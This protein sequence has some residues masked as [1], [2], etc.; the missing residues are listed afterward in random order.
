MKPKR[1]TTIGNV[2]IL[3]LASV[4][5]ALAFLLGA[6]NTAPVV[7]S[8]TIQGGNTSIFVGATKTLKATVLPS[9]AP[10]TVT[11]STS[12]ATVLTVTTAGVI[13]GIKA[14]TAKITAKSTVDP[15]KSATITVTVSVATSPAVTSVTIDQGNQTLTVGGTASLT[16]TVSAVGGASSDVTWS[17]SDPN[18]A[19][20][21]STGPTAA[22]LTAKA[23][24]T[25]T[26]TA[27]SVFDATKSG[28]ITVTVNLPAADPTNIYV[29]A[30][31][32]AGGN[33]SSAFP[34]QTINDGIAAVNA[35]GTVHVAAGTYPETLYI[36][37]A[38]TLSGAGAG[39]TIIT[40]SGDA[41]GPYSA[42]SLI[43]VDVN[44]LTL[45]GFTLQTTGAGP[46]TAGI[47]VFDT[48]LG[49]TPSTN[50]TIQNVTVDQQDSGNSSG[51]YLVDVNTATISN[52]TVTSATT[53]RTGAGILLLG[54]SNLTVSNVSTTNHDRYA[55]LVLYPDG[56]TMSNVAVQGTFN[57][58]N[59]MEIRYDN[60]G[61]VTGLTAPQ[62]TDVVRNS[63]AGHANGNYWFYKESEATAISDALFNFNLD[64]P[65]SFVQPLDGTDQA[66]L[67]PEFVIGSADGTSYGW[68][69]VVRA[70]SVQTAIDN[71]ASGDTILLRTGPATS[72]DGAL[73]VTVP[74]LTITGAGSAS[75]LTTLSAGTAPVLTVD[76]NGLTVTGVAISSSDTTN[77]GVLVNNFTGF[78]ITSSNLLTAI[79]MNN[80][81]G[82]VVTATGNWWG[83]ASGPTIASNVGGAGNVL[84]DPSGNVA[85]SGF[86]GTAY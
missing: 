2:R 60:G 69:G 36:T 51:V 22:T 71:A 64:W 68:T 6:C 10:Q 65:T 20:V 53:T 79:A 8:V 30:S 21:A 14:G 49:A 46:T 45:E 3:A 27:T 74:N 43:G 11:W 23:K 29:D 16:A 59:K 55:G 57:E 25:A 33:G 73:D 4:G 80:S 85:Y 63:S 47:D 50:I 9:S 66:L 34:Y 37:K 5:L 41:S 77:P 26:I 75:T 35:G 31:A 67:K 28:S 70:L 12:D 82:N 42:A 19:T 32:A 39:S 81:G 24:G 86:A 48:T 38:L 7:T 15:S 76:A 44:G 61:T 18:V 56:A 1:S 84:V 62:F 52:V 83:D 72:F 40:A 17:S 54:G 58:T 13:K 78:S